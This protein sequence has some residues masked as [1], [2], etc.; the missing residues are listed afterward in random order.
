MTMIR[1]LLCAILIGAACQ[2]TAATLYK[3]TEADGSI[4]FSP[5]PPAAGIAYD[6]VETGNVTSATQRPLSTQATAQA[7]QSPQQRRLQQALLPSIATAPATAQAQNP[8]LQQHQAQLPNIANSPAT[9]YAAAQ[10]SQQSLR[11]QQ[12][13]LPGIATS[14]AAAAQAATQNPLQSLRQQRASLPS[15]ATA[16]AVLPQPAKEYVYVPDPAAAAL[17]EGMA[18]EQDQQERAEQRLGPDKPKTDLIG[19]SKKTSQCLDLEKRVMSLER[20]LRSKL[21]PDDVDNTVMAIVRY[22][23]SFNQFCS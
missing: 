10:N 21:S 5:E 18:W 20:R 7:A 3:W 13:Q 2:A 1:T 22:Q 19:S 8:G 12:A 11:Q 23:D 6:T 14:Q 4:T 16:P 9:T 17:P 15:I